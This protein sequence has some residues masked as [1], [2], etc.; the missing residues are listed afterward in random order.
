MFWAGVPKAALVAGE[1]T[2]NKSHIDN[3]DDP[4]CISQLHPTFAFEKGLDVL[5]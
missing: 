5:V 3:V 4:T 2:Q 1:S